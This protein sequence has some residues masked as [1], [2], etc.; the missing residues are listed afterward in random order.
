MGLEHVIPS[1]SQSAPKVEFAEVANDADLEV[2]VST[3]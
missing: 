2:T 1:Y 3:G